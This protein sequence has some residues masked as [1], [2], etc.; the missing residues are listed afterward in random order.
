MTRQ[1]NGIQVLRGIAALIVVLG[2]NRSLYG[3]IDSGSFI[4][5]LTMQAT[6]G[7]EVFFI[8]SGF[9]ITYSTRNASGDSL[10]RFYSFLTKRIFRI[11]PIYF[12]VLS[13]YISLFCY[14]FK[15]GHFALYE[16]TLSNI[17]KSF[18]L[19][20]LNPNISPPFY[21][22]GTL[23][24]SW[25]LGYEMYFYM[26]FS[27]SLL[28]SKK[29]R[30]YISMAILMAVYLCLS[31]SFGNPIDFNANTFHVPFYGY[32]SYLGF[33]G[34]PIIFD[35]VLGM[36]IAECYLRFHDKLFKNKTI[37]YLSIPVI[38]LCFMMWLT[39]FKSGQGITNTGFIACLI[40]FCAIC[41]ETSTKI[42]FPK[43]MVLMGTCSYSLYLIHVPIK[44]IIEIYGKDIPFIPQE[45][46]VMMYLMSISV[47]ISLSI[48][49]YYLVE[50]KFIDIGHNIS[51]KI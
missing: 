47:S 46:S 49:M 32:H 31:V 20:P 19:I 14:N 30:S 22:W 28:I 8:I 9:I 16:F 11:Y 18:L 50:K 6:F 33:I 45:P 23:I 38:T 40:V 44:K 4:D 10:S 36:I 26:V 42:E 29:Y 24:V 5:Y 41:I 3:H 15:E 12:I 1:L 25:T 2:H 21:G 13:V 34:N 37:G 27:F 43:F 17:I 39:G 48:P 51:K 7:V 35:F